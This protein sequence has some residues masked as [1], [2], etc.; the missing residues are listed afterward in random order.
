MPDPLSDPVAEAARDWLTRFVDM[1][2]G[3]DTGEND[4]VHEAREKAKEFLRDGPKRSDPF[5]IAG[6]MAEALPGDRR[7]TSLAEDWNRLAA[8]WSRRYAGAVRGETEV[9]TPKRSIG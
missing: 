6:M 8:D 5:V 3:I 2:E 1:Y 9:R 7:A 4:P